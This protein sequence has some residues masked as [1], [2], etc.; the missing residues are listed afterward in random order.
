MKIAI[1]GSSGFVGQLIG[2]YFISKNYTVIPITRADFS[3]V[4]LLVSK[5]NGTQALINCTG[6]PIVGKFITQNYKQQIIDSRICTTQLLVQALDLCT[7]KPEV[8]IQTSAI[9]IYNNT[10]VHDEYSDDF[11]TDFLGRLVIDWEQQAFNATDKVRLCIVRLGVVLD[12][13]GGMLKQVQKGYPLLLPFFGNGLQ[14]FSFITSYDLKRACHFLINNRSARG[15]FNLTAPTFTTQR[16]FNK[17]LKQQSFFLLKV[18]VPD[19]IIKFLFKENATLLTDGQK[20]IPKR[21]IDL[22]F[23]FKFPTIH[24][25]MNYFFG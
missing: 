16:T 7:D 21:L 10:K 12:R 24:K 18:R 3:S 23:R 2:Q 22:G 17:L 5:I 1:A 11:A 4:Q 14:A 20:V 13:S 25:A 9:G 19:F 15:I 8:F 6:A